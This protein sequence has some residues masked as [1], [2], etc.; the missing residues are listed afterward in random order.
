MSCQRQNF[1]HQLSSSLA[2]TKSVIVVEDLN[3]RGMLRNKRLALS[4]ADAGFGELRRQLAYKSDWY[5]ATLVT[6]GRFYPSS[7]T[8]SGCGAIKDTLTLRE[9]VFHCND[10][11]LSINR[12]ENAAINL[13]KLG[14]AHLPEGLRQVTPVERKG[15]APGIDAPRAKPASMKQEAS[16]RRRLPAAEHAEARRKARRHGNELA[17][18]CQQE[19]A[20]P[21]SRTASRDVPNAVQLDSLDQYARS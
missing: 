4:I 20:L 8:C 19:S 15:R 16:G 1:L 9:R 5:G 6:A 21:R 3:V 7:K 11:G 12:D 17:E 2:K 14:I 18:S 10:C 13:R